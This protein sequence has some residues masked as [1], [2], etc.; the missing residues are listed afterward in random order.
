MLKKPKNLK[1]AF[2]ENLGFFQP[3]YYYCVDLVCS[4]KSSQWRWATTPSTMVCSTP[5]VPSSLRKA[6]Q[7]SGRDIIL[8]SCY[9]SSM[10]W[11]RL[12]CSVTSGFFGVKPIFRSPI[13]W[14]L[15]G[16]GF[17]ALNPFFK[18]PTW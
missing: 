11:C 9:R 3:C 12:E 14:V 7:H 10:A 4:Y 13:Q 1:K 8:L 16:L 2:F 6:S 15:L 5:F 17:F 18:V